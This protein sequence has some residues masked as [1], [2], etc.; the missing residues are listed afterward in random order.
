MKIFGLVPVLV[1]LIGFIGWCMNIGAIVSTINH[2][3]TGMFIF[4]CIGVVAA[5]LGA[6]LG[7][8]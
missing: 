2:P 3:I 6:I 8:F 5:P 7:F 4:R 1:F